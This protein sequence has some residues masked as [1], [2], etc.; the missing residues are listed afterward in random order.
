MPRLRFLRQVGVVALILNM[1]VNI[2]LLLPRKT[3]ES[4][5]GRAAKN[6]V[7]LRTPVSLLHSYLTITM[8]RNPV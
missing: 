3:L 7:L 2:L 6:R 1:S 5:T 8:R 4:P